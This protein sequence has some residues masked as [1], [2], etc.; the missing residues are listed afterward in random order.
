[1]NIASSC[2]TLRDL[3]NSVLREYANNGGAWSVTED[4]IH[5]DGQLLAADTTAGVS[6]FHL[7]HPNGRV[8]RAAVRRIG[9]ATEERLSP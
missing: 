3:G 1:M 7:D 4:F 9:V 6:H 8:V 5:R 2:W